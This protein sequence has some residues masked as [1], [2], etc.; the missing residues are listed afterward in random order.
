[1]VQN[2]L[3][4]IPKWKA[5]IAIFLSRLFFTLSVGL[6]LICLI[7]LI[8]R[9]LFP[10]SQFQFFVPLKSILLTVEC[11][12]NSFADNHPFI[13][14]GH[15]VIS[16]WCVTFMKKEATS[17]IF[18]AFG[19]VSYS[20]AYIAASRERTLYGIRLHEV[21]YAL[22]PWYGI[23]YGFHG[24]WVIMG[25]YCSNSG[26][27]VMATACMLGVLFI[28]VST[29]IVTYLFNSDNHR[30]QIMV[31]YYFYRFGESTS[32]RLKKKQ[33]SSGW[34][35]AMSYMICAADYLRCYYIST[36]EVPKIVAQRMWNRFCYSLTEQNLP[37]MSLREEK[38]KGAIQRMWNRF[39]YS[40]TRGNLP[41]KFLWKK[42]DMVQN[43]EPETTDS[44]N[45][46]LS[47]LYAMSKQITQARSIW[48]HM[49]KKFSPDKQADFIRKIF[50][51][52]AP[53]LPDGVKPVLS[54]E[55][56]ELQQDKE[57][58]SFALPLCGLISYLLDQERPSHSAE[59]Y[60]DGWQ[61]CVTQVYLISSAHLGELEDN[62][63]TYKYRFLTQ[64]L[65]MIMGATMMAECSALDDSDLKLGN[66]VWI[67][68]TSLARI[69]HT[70][71]TQFKEFLS[72]GHSI[73]LS[74]IDDWFSAPQGLDVQQ[75][76]NM[77][78]MIL[79]ADKISS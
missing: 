31:E 27:P 21:M 14:K 22:F 32:Y 3:K 20:Y 57:R 71:L 4:K 65:F 2:R 28:F 11:F 26:A 72:W 73:T 17:I 37:F 36:Q 54:Q 66:E 47:H 42:K 64:L 10:L 49:L 39:R 67:Q 7:R 19:L 12:A 33:R 74:S 53:S 68:I 35:G 50:K 48:Q 8:Y 43:N 38:K 18:V 69:M 79:E 41:F 60:W 62:A 44:A 34:T 9:F 56:L 59:T 55:K 6:F 78:H 29:A 40:L 15:T 5:M 16:F 1:M 61:Q 13:A 52:I 75:T 24:A 70:P 30:K 58:L 63:G 25:L 45:V 51:V 77:L 23:A 46:Q 76:Y